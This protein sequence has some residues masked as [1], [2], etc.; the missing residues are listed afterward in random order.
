M[1]TKRTTEDYV[2][3]IYALSKKGD[4]RGC[5]LADRLS[6]SRPTVSVT[7]KALTEEGFV[8]VDARKT[9]HLTKQ[10]REIAQAVEERHRVLCDL[11]VS[12]GVDIDI[13]SRDACRMEHAIGDESFSALKLLTR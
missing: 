9:V 4:V 11:L 2:K 6:V 13:A 5:Q 1:K 7:L 10:G 8:Y 3:T 12:L